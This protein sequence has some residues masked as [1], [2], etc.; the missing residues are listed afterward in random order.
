[1]D[2]YTDY[3]AFAEVYNRHWGGFASRVLPVVDRLVLND[4]GEG[5]LVLDLCCGTGHL[6]AALN[7]RG[8]RVIGIDGSEA[9]V[10][11]A[12]ENAPESEFIVADARSFAL[13][14]PA[15]AAVSTYDSLNHV[16]SRPDLVEVFRHTHDALAAGAQFLFDLNMLEGFESR[17]HG[18]FG[19]VSD[20]EVIVGRS[21]YD[22]E[23][24]IGRM[25]FT[26]MAPDGDRWQRSDVAFTQ[27]CYSEDA[28]RSALSE[29]GL[30]EA[31][32]FDARD[33]GFG[34]AGRSF[35]LC[36]KPD[37]RPG[38]ANAQRR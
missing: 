6:A 13:A 3:D 25:D 30:C 11:F 33:V 22:P 20:D 32:A 28:I 10:R 8:F 23:E 18:T 1:M 19:I 4:L 7:E 17:W 12:R 29:A 37:A 35:F 27:R 2:R 24:A 21:R 5:S 36:R 38:S 26:V 15:D 16:M 31:E 14:T 34:D 9:M